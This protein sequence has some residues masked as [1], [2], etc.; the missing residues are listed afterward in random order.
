MLGLKFFKV[1]AIERQTGQR[2]SAFSV[3]ILTKE[4]ILKEYSAESLPDGER[5]W[6]NIHA[7]EIKPEE[8]DPED[9]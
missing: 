4:Q 7:F 1:S 2:M 6:G 8:I 3:G 5:K 9:Y